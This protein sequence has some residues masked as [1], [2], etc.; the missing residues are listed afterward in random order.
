MSEDSAFTTPKRPIAK[1]LR[2]EEEKKEPAQDKKDKMEEDKID[3]VEK[4]MSEQKDDNGIQETIPP[5]RLQ[6]QN[7]TMGLQT[8]QSPIARPPAPMPDAASEEKEARDAAE[9]IIRNWEREHQRPIQTPPRQRQDLI[10][11]EHWSPVVDLIAERII[12]P[13]RLTRLYIVDWTQIIDLTQTE[14]S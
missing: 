10:M 13:N 2:L 7:A 1:K 14:N 9:A 6:R 4:W 5:P 11:D 12:A 3:P 8:F